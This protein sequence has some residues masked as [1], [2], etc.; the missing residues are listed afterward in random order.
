MKSLY[1]Y[2][3]EGILAGREKHREN[4]EKDLAD[5]LYPI[6]TNKDFFKDTFNSTWITWKCK[7][8][9]QPLLQKYQ[10][11]LGKFLTPNDITGLSIQIS[12]ERGVKALYVEL[13]LSSQTSHCANNLISYSQ[14]IDGLPNC[15]KIAL[16][17]FEHFQKNPDV[18][19]YL[20]KTESEE[21]KKSEEAIANN[22]ISF[23]DARQITN[24]LKK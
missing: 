12:K 24:L 6:P 23:T 16:Q 20:I 2:I 14:Y 18:L 22:K 17:L 9:I 19:E 3:K 11:V 21:I 10:N 7:E 13:W 8:L 5:T 4:S 1:N 15:K